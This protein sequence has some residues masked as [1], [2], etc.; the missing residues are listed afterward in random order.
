[1]QSEK[2][3]DFYFAQVQ[4]ALESCT[5]NL[6]Q[7]DSKV[8]EGARYSLMNGGKRVRGVLTLAVCDMLKGDMEGAAF[9]AAAVEMVHAYS[10]VHD[11][12][13]CMDNDD[14][15][16][17]KPSCHKAFDETTALLAG[18]ALLT[19]AF[20]VLASSGLSDKQNM[21]AVQILSGGA[22][23]RG[24]IYGQELDLFF[25]KQQTLTVEEL[26]Q[27]HRHKTG[28]LINAAVQM[29][30]VAAEATA[31]QRE[32]LE[33]FALRL[34]FVFQI[35]DDVLDV[36]STTD[37]LGKPVGSDVHNG[38]ITFASLKG[39]KGCREFAAALTQEAICILEE[40]FG[41]QA[42]FLAGYASSLLER[43]H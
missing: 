15:R 39:I 2:T 21:R 40:T 37:V 3:Y 4:K 17:G 42:E 22:G 38:K 18:D 9:Y 33:E 30:A 28:A 16:R 5:D 1:M 6:W 20:E 7:K 36:I 29:G 25:E 13:P 14:Y 27:V 11:D 32:V 43:T 35:V 26:T 31:R 10:L 34:G 24:M 41:A 8:S 23:A 12:L 19:E